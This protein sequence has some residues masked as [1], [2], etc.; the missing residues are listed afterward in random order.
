MVRF[1]SRSRGPR[2]ASVGLLA[3]L[4][5]CG[6]PEQQPEPSSSFVPGG[7]IGDGVEARAH[8]DETSARLDRALSG[9]S[10]A[11]PPKEGDVAAQP[12]SGAAIPAAGGAREAATNGPDI[13]DAAAGSDEIL[14]DDLV[15]AVEITETAIAPTRQGAIDAATARANTSASQRRVSQ[16]RSSSVDVL[17]DRG[18]DSFS[19]ITNLVTAATLAGVVPEVVRTVRS[20]EGYEATVRIRVPREQLEPSRWFEQARRAPDAMARIGDAVERALLRDDIEAAVLGRKHMLALG[21]T[22]RDLEPLVGLLL[23]VGM[24]QAADTELLSWA[25]DHREDESYVAERR[26]EIASAMRPADDRIR[27]LL[28]DTARR[29]K[30]VLQ[31]EIY[32]KSVHVDEIATLKGRIEPDGWLALIWIDHETLAMWEVKS[33]ADLE[34]TARK[35]RGKAGAEG[36]NFVVD[37]DFQKNRDAFCVGDVHLLVIRVAD[38]SHLPA[39]PRAIDLAVCRQGDLAEMQRF[40]AVETSLR[41]A[42]LDPSNQVCVLNWQHVEED[43]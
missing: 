39:V 5:A 13:T 9:E 21:G 11:L 10:V 17:T 12:Y 30:G 24:Y 36:R 37:F 18:E 15:D 34:S 22:R 19:Q 32:P 27:D 16:V 20:T 25:A 7:R 41:E 3:L 23:E 38:P 33:P 8:R 2:F 26:R 31:L 40:S 14:A 42:A 1:E 35:L 29:R 6:S 43:R 28:Q 4:A